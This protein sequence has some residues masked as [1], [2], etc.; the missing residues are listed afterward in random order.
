MWRRSAHDPERIE[1]VLVHRPRYD[2]WSL[3]KGKAHRGEDDLAT[4]LREVAEETGLVC[5]PGAELAT[6][7][8]DTERGE[9]KTVRWWSMTV[10]SDPGF[11]PND[12]VDE[13]RWVSLEEFEALATFPTDREVVHS[14][15][16]SHVHRTR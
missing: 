14:F 6:V 2:D 1:L 16:T 11:E 4:A 9:H 12:E 8:Y 3:P 7:R 13:L 15:V 5:R 10:D